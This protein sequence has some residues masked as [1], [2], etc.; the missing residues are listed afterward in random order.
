M[1]KKIKSALLS[2]F[3]KDGLEPLVRTLNEHGVAIYSTGGT[4]QF[5]EQL[6]IEC[7]PWRQG[8]NASSK[9]IW[10]NSCK[11]SRGPRSQ[12]DERI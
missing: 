3:Y 7:I 8:Q 9:S 5:I 12:R 6:G 1:Q 4:Q 2:V 11:K 10:R